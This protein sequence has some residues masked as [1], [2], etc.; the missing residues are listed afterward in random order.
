[1]R[2]APWRQGRYCTVGQPGRSC[3][4]SCIGRGGEVYVTLERKRKSPVP[5]TGRRLR[6]PVSAR[7]LRE[8]VGKGKRNYRVGMSLNNG[9]FVEAFVRHSTLISNNYIHIYMRLHPT[10][11]RTRTSP[12]YLM[13][14]CVKLC[15][16]KRAC[17]QTSAIYIKLQE[18][19]AF[20]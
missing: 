10:H 6:V 19:P 11:S 8:E 9:G 18:G 2:R 17:N 15:L 12:A 14:S 3:P 7:H 5:G 13:R 4:E 20:M 1:M 16:G